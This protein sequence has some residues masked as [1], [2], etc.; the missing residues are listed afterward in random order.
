MDVGGLKGLKMLPARVGTDWSRERK[1][2]LILF[3]LFP[4]LVG[5]VDAR[6][7]RA[8]SLTNTK[9]QVEAK[10]FEAAKT[11]AEKLAIAKKHF[12]TLPKF[13]QV[14]DD[15][16]NGRKPVSPAPDEV[17]KDK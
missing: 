8:A 4:L 1:L 11:D 17:S 2:R 9:T 12:D 13:T 5:C 10:E 16:V 14:L 7:R 15:Y 3:L 6:I